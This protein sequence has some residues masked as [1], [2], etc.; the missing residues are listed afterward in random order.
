MKGLYHS[1]EKKKEGFQGQLAIV[2]PKTILKSRCEN[3]PVIKQLYVTDIGYYPKAR[4]H[5]RTRP[6]GAEQHI[7]I[8]CTEGKGYVKIGEAGFEVSGG[9]YFIVPRNVPHTYE[10]DDNCP[11]SI[12]W[13][14]FK[15]AITD[16]LVLHV[17][18]NQTSA[19]GFIKFDE[20]RIKIFENIYHQLER[21]YDPNTLLY[22]S[23]NLWQYLSTFMFSENFGNHMSEKVDQID[24]VINY[25]RENIGTSLSLENLAQVV[26]LSQSHFSSLFKKKTG[27]A[28]VDYFN[29]LKIQK[30]CQFLRFSDLRV[31]EISTKLGFEDQ[32]YFSRLFKKI[33]GFS[34]VKYKNKVY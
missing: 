4:L 5:Y 2:I 32:Y 20:K 6:S 21:G 28:P 25:M 3:N 8:Y 17:L 16:H 24:L 1:H 33:M 9:Q 10:A 7:L 19:P 27:F 34:P 11:W 29:H 15:G 13:I 18:S 14:H 12:Y 26:N 31:K 23:M 22:I 30:A